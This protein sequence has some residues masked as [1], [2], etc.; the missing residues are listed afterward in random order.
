MPRSILELWGHT[1][2]I[3]F[4]G[5]SALELAERFAPDVIVSDLGLPGMDGFDLAR[6]LRRQPAFGR[7]VLVAMSGYGREEDKRRALEAGFDHHLVKPPDLGALSE[8]FGRVAQSGRASSAR[9][10]H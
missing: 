2:E 6:E 3:A 5:A 1:V 4:D 8:L 9:T 7:V 10:V